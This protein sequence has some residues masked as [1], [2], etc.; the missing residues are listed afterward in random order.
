YFISETVEMH[1]QTERDEN[2]PDNS[3]M[4]LTVHYCDEHKEEAKKNP[5]K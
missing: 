1:S 5:L 3:E 2:D 4:K